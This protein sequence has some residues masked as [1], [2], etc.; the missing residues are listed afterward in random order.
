MFTGGHRGLLSA[1]SAFIAQICIREN[2]GCWGTWLRGSL[3]PPP[4]LQLNSPA[5]K[6][7][8]RTHSH[9]SV[10]CQLL[11]DMLAEKRVS[12]GVPTV[13]RVFYKACSTD[14]VF[15]PQAPSSSESPPLPHLSPP[16]G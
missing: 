5:Q 14:V 13:P 9:A 12:T 16:W 10:A 11:S 1:A 2:P 3:H 7:T 8:P 6:G 15:C 4:P